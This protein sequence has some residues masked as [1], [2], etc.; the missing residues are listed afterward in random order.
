MA[1]S[2]AAPEGVG[3]WC[4]RACVGGGVDF[5]FIYREKVVCSRDFSR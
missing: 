3:V 5:Y 4:M 2:A 1:K